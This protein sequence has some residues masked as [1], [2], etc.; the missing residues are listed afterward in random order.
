MAPVGVPQR[1]MTYC[2]VKSGVGEYFT[3]FGGNFR[4]LRGPKGIRTARSHI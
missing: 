1:K 3:H 4:E 2:P